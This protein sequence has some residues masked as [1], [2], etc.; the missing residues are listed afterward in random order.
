MEKQSLNLQNSFETKVKDFSLEKTLKCGQTFRFFFEN[1]AYYYP[2]KESLIKIREEIFKDVTKLKVEVF[3]KYLSE[4]DFYSIFGLSH[5][6]TRINQEII[7][8][9]PNLKEVVEF[10]KGIRL[11]KMEP[12]ETTISFIFSIQSQIPVITS[13]LNKLA[14]LTNKSIEVDGLI[15]YLFPRRMDM[16]ELPLDAISSLRLGFREKF[17]LNLIKN[18]TEED[19]YKIKDLPYEEKKKFLKSILGIGDKV[20]ECI[21]LFGYGD[22]SA[23]PVDTWIVKGLEKFFGIKGSIRKLTGFGRTT[24]GNLSGYAQQYIYY[25]M[26]TLMR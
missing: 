11:M 4:E 23:F 13:R 14:Y 25:Y 1:G 26:R 12:Y 19:L 17:F 2:Y 21:I 15:F 8:I 24:F 5:D 18:Y 22:L 10:S 20:S 16:L 6:V 3:G 9:A 7:K